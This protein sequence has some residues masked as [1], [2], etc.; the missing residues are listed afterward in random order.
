MKY[1]IW[2]NEHNAWWRPNGNGYTKSIEEA[3]RYTFERAA[4]ICRDANWYRPQESK[5]APDESIVPDSFKFQ[6]N[7]QS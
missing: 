3:G 4:E 6:T 1:L 5:A 2:S 7:H